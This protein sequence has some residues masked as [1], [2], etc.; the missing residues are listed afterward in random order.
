VVAR[1]LRHFTNSQ[2]REAN[3]L[4]MTSINFSLSENTA[5]PH[6]SRFEAY[7]IFG[8]LQEST[9]KLGT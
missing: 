7:L 1:N 3:S 5:N 9:L 6:I 4:A 2:Q 8:F